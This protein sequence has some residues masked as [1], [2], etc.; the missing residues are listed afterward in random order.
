MKPTFTTT[1]DRK[2]DADETRF[3]RTQLRLPKT[4]CNY[5]TSTL[6]DFNGRCADSCADK[7]SF[8][9]ISA[10]YFKR[11]ARQSFISEAAFFVM[12]IITAAVP[13]VSNAHALVNLL[14]SIGSI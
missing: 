8:R 4:D 3:A 5:H 9:D 11:E 2:R 1:D 7:P 13:L 6:T 12:I 10:G 14:R